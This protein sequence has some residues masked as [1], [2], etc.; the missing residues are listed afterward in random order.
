MAMPCMT[1]K[2]SSRVTCARFA[3]VR[4]K[5]SG[6]SQLTASPPGKFRARCF[7]GGDAVSWDQP[8]DFR[9]TLAKRAQATREESFEVMH[10][11]AKAAENQRGRQGPH[12]RGR[13]KEF[14]QQA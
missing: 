4:R 8:D 5:S 14:N 1:S 6:W 10:G 12:T 11:S 9:L 7:P 13:D 2:N 3:S